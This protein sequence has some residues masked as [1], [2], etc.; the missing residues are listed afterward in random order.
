MGSGPGHLYGD[1]IDI[2]Q[3]LTVGGQAQLGA[4]NASSMVQNTLLGSGSVAIPG[5]GFFQVPGTGSSGQGAFT[6]S[7]PAA[8]AFP[9]GQLLVTDPLG[10]FPYL[11]SGTVSM[12]STLV[13]G[14]SVDTV[15]S[16]AG[17]K[18]NVTAGST[19]G[20]WSDGKGWLVTAVSGSVRLS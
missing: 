8:S 18:L 20:L 10:Q 17:T 14:S 7:L 19:V 11:L 13:T 16:L 6:G 1:S 9:G 4:V 12:I 3:N 15:S 2:A 5:T